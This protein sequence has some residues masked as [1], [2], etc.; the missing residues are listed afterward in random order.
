[1]GTKLTDCAGNPI[2]QIACCLFRDLGLITEKAF[3]FLS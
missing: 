1:V 2:A 3:Q